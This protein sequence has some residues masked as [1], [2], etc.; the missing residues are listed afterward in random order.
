MAGEADIFRRIIDSGNPA[1]TPEA[2]RALLQLD[3]TDADQARMEE[4][5]RKS[6]AGELTPDERSE[7]EGYVFVGDVLGM[8]QSRARLALQKYSSSAA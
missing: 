2:A 1:L 6:N 3:F 4:L 5:A 7:F 8:L